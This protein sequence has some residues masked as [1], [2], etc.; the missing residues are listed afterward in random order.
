M[1]PTGMYCPSVEPAA[2]LCT[3]SGRKGAR[4]IHPLGVTLHDLRGIVLQLVRSRPWLRFVGVL[5][6][7]QLDVFKV[8]CRIVIV[9]VRCLDGSRSALL[10]APVALPMVQYLAVGSQFHVR[11]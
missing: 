5:F 9:I 10:P 1:A 4:Q 3:A 11:S 7:F 6:V 8:T 2:P